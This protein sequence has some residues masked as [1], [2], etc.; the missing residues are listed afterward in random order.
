MTG[1]INILAKNKIIFLPMN[2]NSV[3]AFERLNSKG[4]NAKTKMLLSR[5]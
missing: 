5:R 1:I 2:G 4:N 3:N